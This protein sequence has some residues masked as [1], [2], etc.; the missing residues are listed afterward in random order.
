MLDFV[1][2]PDCIFVSIPID[3]IPVKCFDDVVDFA[4]QQNTS[5][6]SDVCMYEDS[7]VFTV[8]LYTKLP[9][10]KAELRQLGVDYTS[11]YESHANYEDN[12]G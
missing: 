9:S 11:S 12:N 5:P 4:E 6:N 3:C 2:L 10:L 1:I 8:P 7:V